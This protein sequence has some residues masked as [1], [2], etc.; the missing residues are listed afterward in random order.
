MD[1]KVKAKVMFFL[2]GGPPPGEVP[3]RP[4]RQVKLRLTMGSFILMSD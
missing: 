4:V 3:A 1:T 2:P